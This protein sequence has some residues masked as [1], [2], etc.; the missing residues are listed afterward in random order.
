MC[1][2]L[3]SE[4]QQNFQAYVLLLVFTKTAREGYIASPNGVNRDFNL[5]GQFRILHNALANMRAQFPDDIMR[6][7]FK[8]DIMRLLSR[9]S[10]HTSS[11]AQ[12]RS[13]ACRHCV[14]T[15]SGCYCRARV[16]VSNRN[17]LPMHLA[18]IARS[19]VTYIYAFAISRTGSHK[20]WS[21]FNTYALS[22]TMIARFVVIVRRPEQHPLM[23]HDYF[24]FRLDFFLQMA[25]GVVHSS[26]DGGSGRT[27]I[28][29]LYARRRYA[30][31]RKADF[32]CA[33][34]GQEKFLYYLQFNSV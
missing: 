16:R 11:T 2:T 6:M 30:R 19:L 29:V 34:L 23:T 3:H 9:A 28:R 22:M 18:F 13:Y 21:M 26:T 10:R 25:A 12:M 32:Q 33:E 14:N 4:P 15:G 17:N 31:Q 24:S 5:D 27:F 1:R 20:C 7:D 8:A